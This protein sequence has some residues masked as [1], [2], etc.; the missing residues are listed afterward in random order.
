MRATQVQEFF[1]DFVALE[2]Y[3]FAVPLPRPHV[4]LQPFAWDFSHSSD[5]ITRATE[6]VAS[7]M[8]SMRRRFQIRF[9]RG[10]EG[11]ERLAQA[12][13][14]LTQVRGGLCLGSCVRVPERVCGSDVSFGVG[15][16]GGWVGDEEHVGNGL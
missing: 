16:V 3:H 14:H 6:G 7:L 4:L 9:Q 5:A 2:S 15:G 8:L 13:H 12:L 1:G 10:S 11:A